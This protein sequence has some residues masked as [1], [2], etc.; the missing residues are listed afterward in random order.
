MPPDDNPLAG[1]NEP[2]G[3]PAGDPNPASN[4]GD[5]APLPLTVE[6]AT[7]MIQPL[8][9]RMEELGANNQELATRLAEITNQAPAAADPAAGVDGGDFLQQFSNDPQA[10]I[11]SRVTEMFKGI[12][13]LISTLIGSG[14]SAFTGIEAQQV[15]QDFGP[16]AWDKFFAKPMDQIMN[17]HRKTNVAALADRNVISKEVNGLKG[18]MFN[19]LE[20]FRA[21]AR[22]TVTETQEGKRKSLIDEVSGHIRTNPTGGIRRV[23]TG[24]E[25]VTD[26]L[27]GYLAERERSIGEKNDP[28]EWLARTDYGNTIEEYQAHQKK[29]EAAKGGK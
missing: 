2:E 5:P 9:T 7:E 10:A 17:A 4:G 22:K 18:A 16:G 25:E 3:T 24:T 6:A 28:S 21:E 27:R 23:D 26:E 14:S 19:D 8:V 1:S 20:A 13:P 11:D 15:D 12:S 29:L